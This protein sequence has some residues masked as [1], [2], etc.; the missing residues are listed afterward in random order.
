[1]KVHRMLAAAVTEL[2]EEILLGNRYADKGIE[3]VLKQHR[4]WGSRDRAFVASYAYDLVRWCRLL[5]YAGT[6]KDQVLNKELMWTALGVLLIRKNVELPDWREFG[7]LDQKEVRKR[8]HETQLPRSIAQSVPDWL[9]ELGEKELGTGWEDELIALNQ[10]APLVI[11]TNTLKI[12]KDALQQLLIKQRIETTADKRFPDALTV[13]ERVNL[14]GLDLFKQGLFEVQDAG[15]QMIA[16][17]LQVEPGMRVVDACAGAGGKTLHLAALM[18]NKGKII[19]LDT[20]GW[21]LDELKRRARRAGAGIIECRVIDSN[22]VI[23][24][25]E[26]SADRLLLDVPCSGLGVLRRNPDAK[27]KLRPEFIDQIRQTQQDILVRYAPM[28]KPGGFMV[29]ATCSILPSEDEMQVRKFLNSHTEFEL[30]HEQRIPVSL[31]YDGFYMALLYKQP[32]SR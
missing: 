17:F 24:R 27:W 10:T 8:L 7:N 5:V 22:K 26:S 28:L 18:K 23:K 11:R 2:G 31:G 1:M 15:S 13:N 21:K 12:K 3:R 16:P 25:L 14:F 30:K 4:K 6:G 32:N 9:D 19:A 20:E 29:Y